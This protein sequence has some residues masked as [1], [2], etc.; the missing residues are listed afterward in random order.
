MATGSSLNVLAGGLLTPCGRRFT[1]GRGGGELESADTASAL[2]TTASSTA[3]CHALAPAMPTHSRPWG[4]KGCCR[5]V[6][7]GGCRGSS[8]GG[9]SGGTRCTR[10]RGRRIGSRG[11]RNRELEASLTS[12]CLSLFSGLLSIGQ[13]EGMSSSVS[14]GTRV[15]STRGAALWPT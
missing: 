12:S 6:G 5:R 14:R 13:C 15:L 4:P 11:T 7:C 2:S 3:S 1:G 8:W 10:G 9:C